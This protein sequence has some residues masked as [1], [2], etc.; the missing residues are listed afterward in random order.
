MTPDLFNRDAFMSNPLP[1]ST[2][3]TLSPEFD[4]ILTISTVSATADNDIVIVDY[5]D[6]KNEIE[7]NPHNSG[8]NSYLKLPSI[9]TSSSV[10]TSSKSSLINRFLRNVTQKKILEATI[11]KNSFFQSKLKNEAKL[12]SGDLYVKGVKP[13]NEEFVRN[14]NDE[15]DMEVEMGCNSLEFEEQEVGGMKSNRSSMYSEAS[16]DDLNYEPGIGEMRIDL[17][18][19]R[20]LK[21]FRDENEL[22]MKAFKL[23]TGYSTDGLM[24]A[25]LVFLTDKTIYVAELARNELSNK[26]VLPY[27]ELD[28]ILMGPMGNTVLLSNTARDMQNVLLTCGSYPAEKLISSLEMCARRGG[29][30]LPA[31]GQLL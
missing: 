23:Y 1:H 18:K 10:S 21:L 5:S 7:N 4:D 25:V 12:F 19:R 16:D 28:V 6:V 24:C 2:S 29:F 3:N 27:A 30:C 20:N 15:I 14:L 9:M 22:M 17:F 13:Q 11:K 26:F 8:T 31:V